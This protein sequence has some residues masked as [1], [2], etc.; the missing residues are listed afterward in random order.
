[1]QL[2]NNNY[3]HF[4]NN[5]NNYSSNKFTSKYKHS[6]NEIRDLDDPNQIDII[7]NNMLV[8]FKKHLIDSNENIDRDEKMLLCNN[9]FINNYIYFKNKKWKMESINT[10]F[11]LGNT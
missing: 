2:L 4:Y 5:T 1:M 7:L 8:S 6:P 10:H 9:L 3:S 11:F